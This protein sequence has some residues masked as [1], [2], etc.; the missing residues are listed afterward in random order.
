MD[1]GNHNTCRSRSGKGDQDDGR[2]HVWS[3]CRDRQYAEQCHHRHEGFSGEH[4]RDSC[5][6]NGRRR[7]QDEGPNGEHER[8]SRGYARRRASRSKHTAPSRK[9]YT[10]RTKKS[11]TDTPF[12]I[13]LVGCPGSGK[14]HFARQLE[15]SVPSKYVRVNQ[16]TLGS[17]KRC[18]E[19]TRNV[20][21]QKKCPIIDRCNF[22]E[23][24]RAHFLEIARHCN[25][26]V[27]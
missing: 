23:S 24:Q 12:M 15:Q 7:N 2:S 26:P 21:L 6:Q 14:S 20:L 18:E 8:D 1:R 13:L 17:R 19:M 3:S 22:D 4:T 25:I 5:D 10:T 11:N 27:D 9:Q 16:D